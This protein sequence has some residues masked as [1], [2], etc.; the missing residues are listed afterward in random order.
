MYFPNTILLKTNRD[1][2]LHKVNSSSLYTNNPCEFPQGF[3]P[4]P[5]NITLRNRNI[6]SIWLEI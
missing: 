4:P 3:R 6:S 5:P 1:L 2:V